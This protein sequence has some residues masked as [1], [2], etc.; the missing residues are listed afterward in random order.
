MQS[1]RWA[2]TSYAEEDTFR[3][4]LDRLLQDGVLGYYVTGRETCPTTGRVHHQTYVETLRKVTM[5]GLKKR[6]NDN[7]VHVEAARGD[8]DSNRTY[9]IKEGAYIEAG[10]LMRQGARND[11][12]RIKQDMA[13]GKRL[14]DIVD[15]DPLTYCR[16]RNGIK[17]LWYFFQPARSEAP[18]VLWL[19]GAPGTG[20]TKYC[21]DEYSNNEIWRYPGRNWFDGYL[22][23]RVALFDD[24]TDD[25]DG[26]ISYALFLQLTDRYP[27][28]VPVKGSHVK[29]TPT[30]IIFTSNR[31]LEEV[32][33]SHRAYKQ[34]AVLRRFTLIKEFT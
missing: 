15:E 26:G 18:E 28:D 10:R 27:M 20:K 32:Y 23:H 3:T 1:R 19:W 7:T 25:L 24:F 9:C 16:Y 2:V 11:L 30:V 12:N 31:P 29:W 8:G 17:D 22:G 14:I 34:L 13:G 6:L 33:R 5:A 21:Y 4:T